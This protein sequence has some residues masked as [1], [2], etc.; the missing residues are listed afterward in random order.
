MRQLR[1]W[2]LSCGLALL[3]L[4]AFTSVPGYV[5]ASPPVAVPAAFHTPRSTYPIVDTTPITRALTYLQASQLSDGGLAGYTAGQSDDFTTIKVALALNAARLPYGYLTASSGLTPRDYLTTRA[6]SYTHDLSGGVLPGRMGLLMLGVVASDADVTAFGTYPTGHA[7]AG[8]SINM[9]N[10]LTNTYHAATGAYSTTAQLGWSSGVASALNQSYA[11]L[12]LAAAQQSVPDAAI[13]FLRDLQETDGGWGYGFGGDVDTTAFAIEALIASGVAPTD[14]AIQEALSFLQSAQIADG[15]WG[16]DGV[17]SADSTAAVIQALVAVGFT[18]VTASWATDDGDPQTALAALQATDGSFTDNALGT[19]HAIAGLAEMPLPI[20]GRTQRAARAL[21]SMHDTQD[22]TGGWMSY[23][24]LS[25]GGSIDAILAFAAAGNDPDTVSA[26]GSTSSAL[27]FL[28]S[29]VFTYTHDDSGLLFPSQTGKAILGIVAAGADPT[30][31]GVNPGGGTLD[32]VS[33]LEGTYSTVTGAYS[34]TA[35]RG[36]SSGTATALS[37]SFAI[38]AL[39]AT[40]H[41][42]PADALTFL[43]SAQ[44]ADGSWGSVDATGLALQ[45]LCAAGVSASDA[46]IAEALAYLQD[47]QDALGGWDN[48]NSTA[49]AIQGL[50]AAGQD[51]NT[52]WLKDGRSPYQALALYQKPD[53]PFTYSWE[54]G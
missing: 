24:S 4:V 18:P 16:Y 20:L 26:S 25:V 52:D 54:E 51:L 49:Y 12:G 1:F 50:V 17:P 29:Q 10:A 37:Q 30:S 8:Q 22:A 41:P 15:S 47:Q 39:A 31:F 35:V 40:D 6:Y 43:R 19:A 48:P 2:L 9:V 33:A 38:L 44:S 27:D 46:D 32:L 42:I 11:L 3:T 7:Q 14:S 34:T 13:T 53:G 23:G 36:Y 28:S 21:A 5:A 45:A